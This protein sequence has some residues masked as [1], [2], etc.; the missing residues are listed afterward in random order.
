MATISWSMRGITC[1]AGRMM[2]E[3]DGQL[4]Q[5]EQIPEVHIAKKSLVKDFLANQK[6]GLTILVN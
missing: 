2:K 4:W 6:S 1:L 5:V 3:A